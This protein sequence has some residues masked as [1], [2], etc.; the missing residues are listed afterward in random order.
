V[1]LWITD[2]TITY[3]QKQ[4]LEYFERMPGKQKP[5]LIYRYKPKS[6]RMPGMLDKEIEG[7]V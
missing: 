6:M 2:K 4:W 3:Y 5:D 1:K 7:R